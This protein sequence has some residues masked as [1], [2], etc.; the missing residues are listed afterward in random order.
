VE[1]VAL[2]GIGAF[3][4]LLFILFWIINDTFLWIIFFAAL[5]VSVLTHLVLNSVWHRG[6]GN[7][8]IIGALVLSVLLLVYTSLLLGGTNAWQIFL[9]IFPTALILFYVSKIRKKRK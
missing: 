2:C 6:K 7:I 8:I 4:L 1:A 5:P 9:L 3:A